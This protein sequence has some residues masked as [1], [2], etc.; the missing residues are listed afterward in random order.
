MFFVLVFFLPTT[1]TCFIPTH[2][3]SRYSGSS[4]GVIFVNLVCQQLLLS[5][6]WLRYDTLSVVFFILRGLFSVSA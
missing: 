5:V 2:T 3:P 4:G 6:V 1:M